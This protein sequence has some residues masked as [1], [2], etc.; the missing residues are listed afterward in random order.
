M[1]SDRCPHCG[2][3]VERTD[4]TCRHCGKGLGG[5]AALAQR[6]KGT[7]MSAGAILF[8][9]LAVL[10]AMFGA[11]SLSQATAGVGVLCLALLLAIF[12]RMAQAAGH[13]REMMNR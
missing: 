2:N 10:L 1:A 12:A 6:P 5:S 7:G 4:Q 8:T 3:T 9:L 11:A 13:H